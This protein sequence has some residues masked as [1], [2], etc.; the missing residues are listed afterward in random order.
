MA[1]F[2]SCTAIFALLSIRFVLGRVCVC[3]RIFVAHQI[4]PYVSLTENFGDIISQAT[5]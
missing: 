1:F 5:V 4:K 2:P 3:V